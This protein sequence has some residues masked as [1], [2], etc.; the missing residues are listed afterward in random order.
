MIV[1]MIV[2][3]GKKMN[4]RVTVWVVKKMNISE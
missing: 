2:W 3:V 4:I 1:R